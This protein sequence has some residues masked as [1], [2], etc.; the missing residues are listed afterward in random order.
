M[1]ELLSDSDWQSIRT[2]LGRRVREIRL[3]VYGEMGALC[4][5]RLKVPYPTLHDYENGCTMPA[6]S[7]ASSS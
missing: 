7:T 4:W 6:E 3:A 5:P 2:E 1:A